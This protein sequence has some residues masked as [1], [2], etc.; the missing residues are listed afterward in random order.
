MNL[1]VSPKSIDEDQIQQILD[2]NLFNHE[3]TLGDAV[4]SKE[5]EIDQMLLQINLVAS[6]LPLIVQGIIFSGNPLTGLAMIKNKNKSSIKSYTVGDEV[7]NGAKV[8][9]I[10]ESRVILERNGGFE[11]ID[12]ERFELKKK[13]WWI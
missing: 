12:I 6:S 5:S 10:Y 3:G 4:D 7:M 2:R 1:A 8:A 9:K 11:Y 13:T